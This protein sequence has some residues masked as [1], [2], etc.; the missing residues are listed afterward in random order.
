M[1]TYS[2][3]GRNSRGQFTRIEVN[4][5]DNQTNQVFMRFT[6]A[7]AKRRAKNVLT[8]AVQTAPVGK[9]GAL[10]AGLG[11][12]QSRDVKGRWTTGYDVFSKAAHSR[13]VMDGTRPHE[14]KGNPLLAFFW[15]KVGKFVVFH[16]VQHPGT[17]ANPFL[18]R[19]LRK[20]AR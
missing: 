15:P 17:K 1:V 8:E 20:A 2:T 6:D 5:F 14:I 7:D 12:G 9:T 3:G 10:R 13:F 18:V 16:S 11:M 19:A 4:L